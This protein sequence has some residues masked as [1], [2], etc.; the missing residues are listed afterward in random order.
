MCVVAACCSVLQ[1]VAVCCSVLQCVAV[2]CSEL[3]CVAIPKGV[4]NIKGRH[5][6]CSGNIDNFSRHLV[7]LPEFHH[8]PAKPEIF[9]QLLHLLL[10]KHKS[11]AVCVC[12]YVMVNS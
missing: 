9:S 2:C 11:R 8:F 12:M 7:A 10:E 6:G 3:Q 4:V 5:N 1:C